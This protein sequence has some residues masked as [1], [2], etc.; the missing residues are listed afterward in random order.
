MFK[1]ASYDI[2]YFWDILDMPNNIISW[3]LI[4][5]HTS[6]SLQKKKTTFKRLIDYYIYDNYL[7]YMTS[8]LLFRH[9]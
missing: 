3:C 1:K 9:W 8:I 4:I 6:G 2:S 5:R 7:D